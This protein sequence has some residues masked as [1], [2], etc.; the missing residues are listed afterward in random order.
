MSKNKDLKEIAPG[1]LKKNDST[2]YIVCKISGKHCYCSGDRL[3]KLAEKYGG[4]NK[5]SAN[6]ESRDAKRLMKA[7]TPVK[8]IQGMSKEELKAEAQMIKHDK[9]KKREERKQKR[10]VKERIRLQHSY[11]VVAPSDV[12]VFTLLDGNT[13]CLRPHLFANNS[14]FCNGCGWYSCCE[15]DIRKWKEYDDEGDR[16]DLVKKTFGKKIKYMDVLKEGE[17]TQN[18]VAV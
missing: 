1:I 5:V 10:E 13:K 17:T 11:G 8:S 9:T 4:M 15:N 3:E 2:F 14:G 6:Y 18:S 16:S 7:K 12:H